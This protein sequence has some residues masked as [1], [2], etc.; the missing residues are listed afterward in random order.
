MEKI[1]K[2]LIFSIKIAVF[3]CLADVV[4]TFEF[5]VALLYFEVLIAFFVCLVLFL[6][7]LGICFFWWHKYN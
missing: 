5:S 3:G 7:G 4:E 1:P 2:Y 6:L